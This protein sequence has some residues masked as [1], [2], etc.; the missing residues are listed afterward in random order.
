MPLLCQALDLVHGPPFDPDGY[1][2]A[3]VNQHAHETERLIEACATAVVDHHALKTRNLDLASDAVLRGMQ[4]L[5]GNETSSEARMCSEDAV[6]NA[7]AVRAAF[8]EL[9]TYLV[10][11]EAAPS[12]E[13]T[14]VY[15]TLVR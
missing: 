11:V 6:G 1:E 5:P 8:T 13:T 10:D 4:G 15:G 2:W 14:T 3:R 9:A 7:T 12:V